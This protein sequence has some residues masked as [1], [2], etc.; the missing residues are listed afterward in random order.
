MD[1]DSYR[2]LSEEENDRKKE[3]ARI[4]YRNISE[5]VSKS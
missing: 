3:Y 5:E 2:G 1:R 4:R